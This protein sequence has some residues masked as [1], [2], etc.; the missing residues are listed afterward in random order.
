MTEIRV[1]ICSFV[2]KIKI[3]LPKYYVNKKLYVKCSGIRPN[4]PHWSFWGWMPLAILSGCRGNIIERMFRIFIRRL[5]CFS[6]YNFSTK[7]YALND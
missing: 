1:P 6:N 3:T 7:F 2:R 4:V 5:G